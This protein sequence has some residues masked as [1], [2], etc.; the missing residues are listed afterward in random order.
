MGF[1][2]GPAAAEVRVRWL[3]VAG[4]SI[5]AGEDTILHDPYLSRPGWLRTIFRRYVPDASV[6]EPLVAAGSPAPELARAD[7]I[8]IGH[9]H[10]DHL[11]DAPWFAQR[12]GAT[13]VGSGTTVAISEGYGVPAEQLR[14]ADPGD[15]VSH[16]AFDVRVVESR[17]A[18]IFFGE[19][20]LPGTVEEPPDGPIHSLSFKLGDAR[21]YLVTHRPSGLRLFLLSSAGY[22]APALEA[23]KAEGVT[24][25]VLLTSVV[26]GPEDFAE[27]L[28]EALRPR[29][30]VPQHFDDFFVPLADPNADAPRYE[31]DLTAFE[32]AARAAAEAI[33]HTVEI[34]RPSLFGAFSF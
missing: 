26:G 24:V 5:E 34:R 29:V 22:H 25:D 2:A 7:L 10:F 12:T 15:T 28:V 18:E 27:R 6:L 23:L 4:F 31:E 14:R 32:D 3:G 8:L 19:P 20:P 11:G 30:I 16:G 1:P 21:G 17:H 33:G 13:V 9:S